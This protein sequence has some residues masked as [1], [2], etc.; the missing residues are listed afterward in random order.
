M[1]I[2]NREGRDRP[3]H[4]L[5]RDARDWLLHDLRR[6]CWPPSAVRAALRVL[7]DAAPYPDEAL[8]FELHR[9]VVP[10][11][12]HVELIGWTDRD[13]ENALVEYR[14]IDDRNHGL[15]D[16]G[17]LRPLTIAAAEFM[18]LFHVE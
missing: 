6:M 17:W 10:S 8:V 2:V 16:A 15:I 5:K 9:D 14:D 18:E 1:T 12:P 7:H 3:W 4:L 11:A 13:G